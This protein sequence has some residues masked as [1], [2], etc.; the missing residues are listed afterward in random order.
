MNLAPMVENFER[1]SRRDVLP[2]EVL[3]SDV[4]WVRWMHWCVGI[5]FMN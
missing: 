2:V 5:L 4:G 3:L 1:C